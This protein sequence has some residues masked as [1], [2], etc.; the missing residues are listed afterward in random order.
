[1]TKQNARTDSLRCVA[2]KECKRRKG[3]SC[4][5]YFICSFRKQKYVLTS[6]SSFAVL[7][8]KN[9]SQSEVNNS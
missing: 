5:R 4:C 9:T 3:D 8:K 7:K 6:K 1:M 2:H